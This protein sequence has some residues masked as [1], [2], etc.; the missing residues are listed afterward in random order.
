M[1]CFSESSS[2]FSYFVFFHE[3]EE[4][5][6]E[7]FVGVVL[8]TLNAE[9]IKREQGPYSILVT[10]EYAGHRLIF[11]SGSFEGCFISIDKSEAWLAKKII[12]A[13]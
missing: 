9:E 13:F 1:N 10:T 7:Q 12:E 8:R 3:Y 6:F 11:T 2:D 5:S 4:E